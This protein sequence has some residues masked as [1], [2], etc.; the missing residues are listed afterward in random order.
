MLDAIAKALSQVFDP[1]FLGVLIRSLLLTA[2]LLGE[3]DALVVVG[4][5]GTLHHAAPVAAETGA[6]LYHYPMGTENLFARAFAMRAEPGAVVAAL[7]AGRVRRID[8]GEANGTVFVLMVGVGLDGSVVHRVARARRKAIGHFSYVLPGLS[9][10]ARPCLPAMTLE[11]DGAVLTQGV[12]GLAVVGNSAAYGLRLNLCRDASMVDGLLDVCFLPARTRIKLAGWALD[13]RRGVHTRRSGAIYA[14]GA[15]IRIV[16]PGE[17]APVQLD[18]EALG[19]R[20][21]ID[22]M[23]PASRTPIDIRVRP[24]AMRVLLPPDRA[25]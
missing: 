10:L 23:H 19:V 4:G 2:G 5:D 21:G 25:A 24:A 9:E 20:P 13:A 18:G 7:R 12:R 22:L 1:R 14:R 16:N 11:V 15:H 17:P 8:L 3:A 6:L